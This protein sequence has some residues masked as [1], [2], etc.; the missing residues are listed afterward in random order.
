MVDVQSRSDDRSIPLDRVGVKN[1]RYPIVVLDK[2]NR[3]QRTIARV[4]LSANLPHHFKGTHMSRFL[5]V[6]HRHQHDIRMPSYLRMVD[7]I[8][9]ALD[10]DRAFGRLEFPYFIER[11]A[12]VS[13][14]T[15][16]MAYDCTFSGEVGLQAGGAGRLDRAFYVGVEVPV[17]TLCPCSKEISDRGAHNQRGLVRV[18]ALVQS[19]FWIEDL[20]ERIEGCAS[21]ALYPILKREDEKWVT[22]HAYDHPVFVE[23]VVR[24]VCLAVEEAYD[25]PW[26][27]V[28][29]EN[30]ESIHNHE[31]Y[32]YAERGTRHELEPRPTC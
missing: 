15:S 29:A 25:F 28:E 13:G 32:A 12:P 5:E 19:F 24:N 18:R 10:A 4:T 8:R 21:G 27:C 26:F 2:E 31:A 16:C 22:E 7:Q 17:I 3:T 6:F 9:V 14:R 30:Q 23:D 11:T 1:V 20:I